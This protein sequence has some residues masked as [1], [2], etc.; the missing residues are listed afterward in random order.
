MAA[1]YSDEKVVSNSTF[2]CIHYGEKDPG[3][4]LGIEYNIDGI[5]E[6]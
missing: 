2:F 4:L 1:S 6:N 3:D 5:L